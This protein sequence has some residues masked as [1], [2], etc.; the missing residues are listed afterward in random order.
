MKPSISVVIATWQR[1]ALLG[2]CL[3]A[4][5]NQTIDTTSYEIIIVTDGPDHETVLFMK[6]WL[7]SYR[8]NVAVTCL[9]LPIKKGPAAA[10]NAGW[11]KAQGELIVFTDDDCVPQP[12]CLA[13]Y[14]AAYTPYRDTP[15]AFS[16]SIQVPL[17]GMPTDYEMNILQLEQARF[18]TANCACSR[19]ALLLTNGLDEEFTM[20]W[21]EDTA[22]EFDLSEK[23]VPI[24]KVPGAIIQHPV[25]TA[26]WG[27]SIR[28]QKKSMFNAL[29]Y[30]KHPMLFKKTNMGHTPRY[31]YL[32]AC[33]LL[34]ALGFAFRNTQVTFYC[35]EIWAILTG[36][37]AF[38]RLRNTSRN[39]NHVVEMICTS[40]IIPLLS[41]YW[42]LYG[43]IKF[44]TLYI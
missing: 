30:K 17:S 18:V 19:K 13:Q 36:W 39:F 28:E 44:K 22:L 8:G 6:Q 33:T 32:I 38:K 29:L 10:R 20:A 2:R 7:K 4:L 37:F 9:S 5:L 42:N 11:R 12:E 27:V 1:T 14:W 40:A 25:R 43:A 15:I 24:L 34:M 31:Y 16:G 23:E 3:A 35:L 26:S 41:I 21:R